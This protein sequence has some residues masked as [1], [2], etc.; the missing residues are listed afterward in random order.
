V[1]SESKSNASK[2]YGATNDLKDSDGDGVLDEKDQC[3]NE[4]GEINLFGC[5][6]RDTDGDG[7]NDKNDACPK[8]KGTKE[9]NGC[10]KEETAPTPELVDDFDED[11]KVEITY[12]GNIYIIKQGFASENGM[13]YNKMKLRYYNSKWQKQEVDDASGTWKNVT[14][15]DIAFI[16]KKHAAKNPKTESGGNSDNSGTGSSASGG[17]SSGGESNSGEKASIP[18]T[19]KN[20]LKA[21]HD[22]IMKDGAVSTVEERAWSTL[23]KGKYRYGNYKRDPQIESWNDDIMQ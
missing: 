9:N 12:N 15:A 2:K 10:V 22:E 19:N 6:D 16:L 13:V 4:A 7:V 20:L 3:P 23:Y 18:Q 8:E 1:Y 17:S 5:P 21:K 14:K 11:K